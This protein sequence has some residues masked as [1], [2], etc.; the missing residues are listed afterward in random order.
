[1]PV[2][3]YQA[4]GDICYA[5]SCFTQLFGVGGPEELVGKPSSL[6]LGNSACAALSSVALGEGEGMCLW[7]DDNQPDAIAT[8]WIMQCKVVDW[9]CM[10]R[11]LTERITLVMM[12][13]CNRALS[14]L[15]ASVAPSSASEN[16]GVLSL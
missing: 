4:N 12:L 10:N 1:M 2:F 3:G 9:P 7:V 8:P 5:N 11:K 6:I 16:K 15:M 14:G 13:R